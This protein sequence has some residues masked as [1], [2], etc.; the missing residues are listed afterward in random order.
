MYPTNALNTVV[1]GGGD[2]GVWIAALGS[3][4]PT[5]LIPPTDPFKALGWLSEDGVDDDLK[6]KKDDFR[7]HQGGQIVRSIY[8]EPERTF[9]FQCLE[10]TALT[11]GLRHPG[12]TYSTTAGVAKAVQKAAAPQ[13]MAFVIDEFDAQ[14]PTT[15]E[16]LQDRWV[17]PNGTVDPSG[18]LSYKIS[19]MTVLEFLLTPV[20]PVT[21]MTNRPGFVTTP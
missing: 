2:S 8:S 12:A 14:Q 18:T 21:H 3:T 19:G 4:G 6:W 20:G 11:L 7:G 10:H 5:T 13:S 1:G 9:K 15:G 17:I 16:W